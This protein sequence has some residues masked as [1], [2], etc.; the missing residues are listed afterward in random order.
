MADL[1]LVANH[2]DDIAI[3]DGYTG[4]ALFFA[5]TST[6]LGASPD[7][8]VAQ[9]R[10]FSMTPATTLP[11][12]NCVV[13]LTEM[14][15]LGIGILDGIYG[16]PIRKS[17][18]AKRVTDSVAI[19]TP[20]QA[21]LAGAGTVAYARKQYLKDTVNGATDAEYD[22]FWEVFFATGEPVVKGSIL[23]VGSTYYRVRSAH[24]DEA[25]FINASS[26]ELD[27]GSYV[28]ITF[29]QTGAYDPVTDSYSAG[30]L[31]TNG[32][33]FDRYKLYDQLTGADRLNHA[34][35][36]T[37][38]VAASDV[39]PVIGRKVT[40][41]GREWNILNAT[42]EADAWTLHLRRV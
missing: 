10:V 13:A 21:C 40:V 31:T 24:L 23:K 26:D 22:P 17:V 29:A 33:M 35:D 14:Y 28:A 20:G 11:V 34:G 27:S 41:A 32:F 15:L 16:L 7:G 38:I 6:F 30:T 9:K 37:A 19:L 2:F 18:W 42:A 3:T 25:G 8:S 4:A 39:T 1:F 36:M 12:R 5:Q